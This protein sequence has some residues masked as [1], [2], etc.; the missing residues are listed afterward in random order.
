MMLRRLIAQDGLGDVSPARECSEHRPVARPSAASGHA[1]PVHG[2]V[3]RIPK[4]ST[5]Q[6]KIYCGTGPPTGSERERKEVRDEGLLK[7]DAILMNST[8]RKY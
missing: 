8:E 2:S 5:K 4:G 6:S 3:S 1:R 7:C